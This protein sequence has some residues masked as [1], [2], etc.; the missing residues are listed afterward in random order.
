LE[1]LEHLLANAERYASGFTGQDLPTEP[2]GR[3]AVV[4]CM[5]SR[6]DLFAVF[7]LAVGE[8]HVLRNAGGIV[9]DDT[10]R[11]LAISQR[12]LGTRS[13]LL[14]HHTRCGMVSF[15]DE[16]LADDLERE[17]GVRP[18]WKAGA[19]RDPVEDLVLSAARIRESPFVPHS[20]EIAAVLYDVDTGGVTRVAV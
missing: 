3:V 13:I 8:A 18:E 4:A 11:S 5:D 9:T 17:T 19:F 1:T 15:T 14:L 7:G 10:V 2:S 6:I 20:D 16:E 12:F